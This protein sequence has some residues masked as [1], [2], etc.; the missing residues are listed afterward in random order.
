M[1]NLRLQC[2]MASNQHY[3]A[4]LI[5]KRSA[6]FGRYGDSFFKMRF[7]FGKRCLYVYC[8]VLQM[9]WGL[10]FQKLIIIAGS[11]CLGL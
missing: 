6:Y 3:L 5:I 4:F 8:K 9:K 1:K 2:S 11:T 7:Q 10:T